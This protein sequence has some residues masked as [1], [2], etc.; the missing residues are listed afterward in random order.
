MATPSTVLEDTLNTTPQAPNFESSFTQV[1][2]VDIAMQFVLL[3]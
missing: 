1:L 3:Q 2:I